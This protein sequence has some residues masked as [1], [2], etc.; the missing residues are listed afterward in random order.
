MAHTARHNPLV[1]CPLTAAWAAVGGKWKLTII[2][3]LAEQPRHFAGLR[4]Q[5]DAVSQGVSQKV[6]AQQLR[7]LIADG[8]VRRKSTG[9]PPAPVIYSLTEYGN[10]VLP[11][12]EMVRVW[13]VGHIARTRERR[14]TQDSLNCL[15]GANLG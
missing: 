1:N 15:A 2:Y 11:M 10:L 3:W 4:R 14:G 7:E 12:L 5:L 8:I 9:G 6:L 13:G